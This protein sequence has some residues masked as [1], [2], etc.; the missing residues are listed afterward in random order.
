ML[1]LVVAL[2]YI[3]FLVHWKLPFLI[4]KKGVWLTINSKN[5]LL[6]FQVMG[7]FNVLICNEIETS[8]I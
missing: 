5:I 7:I 8:S 1:S 4:I 3:F 2:K 6:S